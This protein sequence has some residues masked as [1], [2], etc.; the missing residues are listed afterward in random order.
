MNKYNRYAIWKHF[1]V[2]FILQ[3]SQ[4][5]R[6]IQ[7][8]LYSLASS[9]AALRRSA[10]NSSAKLGSFGTLVN[11]AL[12]LCLIVSCFSST[13]RPPSSRAI[14]LSSLSNSSN[15]SLNIL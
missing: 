3:I 2:W 8:Q 13:N 4:Q 14:S 7:N 6:S 5:S 1:I 11:Q 15:F 10:I 9:F 12:R